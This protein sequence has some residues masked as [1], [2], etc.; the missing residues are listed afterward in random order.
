MAA[1]ILFTVI[2]AVV[3]AIFASVR[4]ED[5]RGI[6]HML[7]LPFDCWIVAGRWKR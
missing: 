6:Y 1:F 3:F 5:E 4:V 2:I 7:R